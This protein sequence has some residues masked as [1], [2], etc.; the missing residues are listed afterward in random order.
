M[1]Y[2]ITF[3]AIEQK[4]TPFSGEELLCEELTNNPL[5]ARVYLTL[6]SRY[7]TTID[8]LPPF[9]NYLI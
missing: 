8:D 3:K 9:V 6:K 5:Q 1:T 2:L 7:T 4:T